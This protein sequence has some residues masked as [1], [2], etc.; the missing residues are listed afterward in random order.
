[1]PVVDWEVDVYPSGAVRL[2]PDIV[3]D[4]FLHNA[5]ARVQTHIH[6]DHLV[7]FDTSK[8]FQDIIASHVSR[9]LLLAMRNADLPYRENLR[10]VDW[11]AEHSFGGSAVRLRPSGHILG[12]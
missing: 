1:M 7:D 2:G 8:G 3:C 9:E 11:G 12:S 5:R 4:G 10:G 6:A